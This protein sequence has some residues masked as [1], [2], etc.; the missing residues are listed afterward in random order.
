VSGRLPPIGFWS[1]ARTD[2]EDSYG[3]LRKLRLRLSAR[4][5][6]RTGNRAT[7]LWQDQ[8]AI[9][10]GADWPRTIDR[11]IAESSFFVSIIIPAFL[12]SEWCCK[13]LLAFADRMDRLGRDD[14]IFPIH[15]INVGNPQHLLDTDCHDPLVLPIIRRTQWKDFTNPDWHAVSPDTPG[16]ADAKLFLGA[17]FRLAED[18]RGAINAAVT[19]TADTAA[20]Q[21]RG[22]GGPGSSSP[23]A[24][25][26]LLPPT[27][28]PAPTPELPADTALA[29]PAVRR[30]P[31]PGDVV[32]DGPDLPEMV[33]IPLIECPLGDVAQAARR[34]HGGTPPLGTFAMGIPEAETEREKA[35]FDWD[36]QARPVHPVT[37]GRPFWIARYPLLRGEYAMFVWDTGYKG[38]RGAWRDPGFPQTDRHPVVNISHGDA[39]AYIRWLNGKTGGGYRLPSEAEWEYGARACNAT[40]RFWGDDWAGHMGFVDPGHGTASV[41]G[42][43]ANPFGLVDMLGNVWEWCADP[44]HDDYNGAP[45]D[46]SVWESNGDNLR[47]VLRGGSWN[48][49]PMGLR[50]GVRIGIGPAGTARRNDF[51]FRPARAY[52]TP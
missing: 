8:E 17:I 44:W 38:D 13:E 6:Q 2:D 43:K 3:W 27:A 29:A 18:I 22:V 36:E 51:G 26:K 50:T 4:L 1:Y 42:R 5:R 32:R 28:A 12:H 9:R 20:T 23:Q 16:D 41:G 49:S 48:S 39:L 35:N 7:K 40:A 30:E 10:T 11:A 34:L 19:Q 14:L 46:G 52:S 25:P 24:V 45:A 15:Y 33:L 47:R 37:I 31:Q 21:P